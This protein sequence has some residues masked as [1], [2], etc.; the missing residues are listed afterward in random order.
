MTSLVHLCSKS[1][2][3]RSALHSCSTLLNFFTRAKLFSSSSST[4]V[5]LFLRDYL[6]SFSHPPTTHSL[7]TSSNS[8]FSSW[9]LVTCTAGIFARHRTPP[10]DSV[11]VS[12]GRDCNRNSSSLRKLSS[13]DQRPETALPTTLYPAIGTE[14][15]NYLA[16]DLYYPRLDQKWL[17]ACRVYPFHQYPFLRFP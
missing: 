4:F 14:R 15:T 13:T 12:S 6:Y 10:G 16:C 1:F 9:I 3:T 7:F 2:S 8:F 17:E 11:A 5:S